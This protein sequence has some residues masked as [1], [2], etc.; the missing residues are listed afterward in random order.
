MLVRRGASRARSRTRRRRPRATFAPPG[1]DIGFGFDA[2]RRDATRRSRAPFTPPS[3][4]SRSRAT[5]GIEEDHAHEQFFYDD[6]TTERLVRFAKQYERPLFLCTPSLAAAAARMTAASSSGSGSSRGGDR[7]GGFSD[8]LLLDRDARW[9]KKLPKGKFRRFDLASPRRIGTRFSYDAVFCDPPFA[10]VALRDLRRTIDLL[11]TD[12]AQRA[13]P[14]WLCFVAD[15]EADVMDAF[16]GYE[17]ERKPPALGYRS[18]KRKTQERIFLY[19]PRA[20]GTRAKAPS[21][22]EAGGSAGDGSGR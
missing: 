3:P 9:E 11:A 14:L 10:N 12:D 6:A 2:T 1:G 18:V 5:Q 21:A 19:G 4:L 15:R 16:E 7:G 20:G 8:Y 13:A 17:L 22:T